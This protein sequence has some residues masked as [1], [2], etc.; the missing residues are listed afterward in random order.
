M[1]L[2][3]ASKVMGQSGAS[4]GLKGQVMQKVAVMAFKSQFSGGGGG[5]GIASLA[6]K[7]L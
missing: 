2:S 1:V 4:D 3:Q 6:S 7:F 5:G